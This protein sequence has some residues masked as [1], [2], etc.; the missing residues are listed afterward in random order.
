M[1][2]T[3]VVDCDSH[4]MEPPDLWTTFIEPRFRD[5]AI[6]I[7]EQDGQEMLVA[8]GQVILPMGL[9][10]LGGANVNPRSRLR[11]D[12]SLRYLDG[13]PPASY[14]P[15]ARARLLDEWGVDVGVLFPTIGILPWPTED[16]DLLNAYARAYNTWQAE[17][18]AS[19]PGRTAPIALLNL[20]DIDEAA[21][22]L[23]RCLDLG[24]KGVFL[25]PEV[26]G[27]HRPGAPHFDPLWRRCE[28]AGVPLCLH[29]IVR[30]GGPA[31]P[32]APWHQ[33]GVDSLFTFSLGAPGQLMPALV[34]MIADGTFDRLPDLRVVCVEAGCGWAPFLMDRM[35]EKFEFF[36][37]TMPVDLKLQPSEYVQRN[38]WLVAEPE[39]RTIGSV[40]ELVG[41]D[42]V[43]WGSDFPHID[44]SLDASKRIHS[45]T[46]SLE[47]D[48]QRAV[49]GGNAAAVF[50]LG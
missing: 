42:R 44:S 17:F 45:T 4:V 38:V 27:G 26:I 15:A 21:R 8:D 33:S 41:E 2:R 43:M 12:P 25:P 46:D 16:Q 22:E 20:A 39:E 13:C 18:S 34:T 36:A 50:G 24:F 40:L 19:I 10:G 32:F 7:V 29:V 11:T 3:P 37:D 23:D 30:F 35:D 1:H 47:I 6:K 48:R 9:A 28:E 14:D 49:L 31:V 5:R